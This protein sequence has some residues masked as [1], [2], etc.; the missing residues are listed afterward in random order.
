MKEHVTLE[1]R[2]IAVPARLLDQLLNAAIDSFGMG[3]TEVMAKIAY[4]DSIRTPV[5][6]DTRHLLGMI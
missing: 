3:I 6:I 1:T 4:S 2:P 5:L